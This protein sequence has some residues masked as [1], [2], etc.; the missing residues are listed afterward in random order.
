ML[1][2]IMMS[3]TSCAFGDVASGS[4]RAIYDGFDYRTQALDGSD[5]GKG[6]WKTEWRKSAAGGVALLAPGFEYK[7]GDGWQL[8][9]HGRRAQLSSNVTAGAY[10]DFDASSAGLIPGGEE[11]GG[12]GVLWMSFLAQIEGGPFENSGD[13]ISFQLRAAKDLPLLTVGVMGRLNEWRI[14]AEG[15]TKVFSRGA[16]KRPP[17]M[18]SW[19]V[20]RVD[21]DNAPGVSDAVHLWVNP[22]APREPSVSLAN[23][24]IVG[25]DLWGAEHPFQPVRLR[26]GT[27]GTAKSGPEK[28]LAWD[29]IRL[30]RSFADVAPAARTPG[31]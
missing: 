7:D 5:G 13:E 20:I 26:I 29:E 17:E 2:C 24:R 4:D 16:A 12:K 1:A 8:A 11:G 21:V 18:L 22:R 9:V 31:D 15:I 28:H 25:Q 19:I 14:R 10:R 30:G 27:I 6:A 23:A 3:V